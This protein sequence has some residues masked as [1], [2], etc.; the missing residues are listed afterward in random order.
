MTSTHTCNPRP[1]TR[2]NN[3]INS[4]SR[5]EMAYGP[6]E[7]RFFLPTERPYS[8]WSWCIW[9]LIIPPGKVEAPMSHLGQHGQCWSDRFGYQ[10]N[11]MAFQ[12]MEMYSGA[13]GWQ[14]HWMAMGV[15][16]CKVVCRWISIGCPYPPLRAEPLRP[17]RQRWWKNIFRK[18]KYTF[19]LNR[20]ESHPVVTMDR[21]GT[22]PR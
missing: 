5:M 21:L 9:Y 22:S 16:G 10:A 3:P 18:K 20:H 12:P 2:T 7:I 14:C 17:G 1:H 11:R 8:R 13:L 6:T 15:Q 19:C 4:T